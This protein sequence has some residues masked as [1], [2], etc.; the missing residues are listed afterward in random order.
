MSAR[1][2]WEFRNNLLLRKQPNN[3][4]TVDKVELEQMSKLGMLSFSTGGDNWT[5][6]DCMKWQIYW[7]DILLCHE[8][9]P[10]AK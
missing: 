6:V 2:T 9:D 10:N 7:G 4:I 3:S 5:I 8:R 1:K